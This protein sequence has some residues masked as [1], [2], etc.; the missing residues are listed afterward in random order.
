MDDLYE[1]L[2][3]ERELQGRIE[4]LPRAPRAGEMGAVADVLVAALGSGGAAAALTQAIHTWIRYRRPT[5]T[6]T[7]ETA[8]GEKVTLTS[9]DLNRAPEILVMALEAATNAAL[10]E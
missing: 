9:D 8:A 7:V 3:G 1:W 2:R 10:K 4:L 6:V 5:V